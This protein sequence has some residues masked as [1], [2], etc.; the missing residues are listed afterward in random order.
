MKKFIAALSFAI[1]L[2]ANAQTIENDKDTTPYITVTGTAEKEVVP[3]II[4]ISIT[5]QEKVVN[6]A[7]YTIAAQEEKLKKSLQALGIDLKN[8]SLADAS[9]E[10]ISYKRK[11]KGVEERQE[12]SLKVSTA[13]EVRKVFEA[14]HDND[15]KEASIAK[16]DH[17]QMDALRKEV[18]IDAIKA[19]K[20]KATYLLQAIGEQPGK[21]LVITEEPDNS[22]L[23]QNRMSNV[24]YRLQ[25]SN[26]ETDFKKIKIK[27]SYYV[28]YSIK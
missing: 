2:S 25:E 18:R 20:D 21:P 8:L 7:S 1:C 15:I 5:L 28:K 3:D 4:Y 14:L 19:A 26:T 10:I 16:V 22:Y 23:P 12:Y 13:T 27:F 6:K 17:T 24:T 9:S 11:D